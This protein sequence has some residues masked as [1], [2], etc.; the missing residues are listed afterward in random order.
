[1]GRSLSLP[2]SSPSYVAGPRRNMFDCRRRVVPSS[3]FWG[4]RARRPA[5]RN[6]RPAGP[7]HLQD[8]S[9]AARWRGHLPGRLLA[10]AD[11]R[12]G[13]SH[14]V[15]QWITACRATATGTTSAASTASGRTKASLVAQHGGLHDLFVP[16]LFPRQ[17]KP[18]W[19]R[20]RSGSARPTHKQI[21]E[22]CRCA[23]R[24]TGTP[25]RPQVRPLPLAHSL[26]AGAGRRWRSEVSAAHRAP[27]APHLP[28]RWA[29]RGPPGGRALVRRPRASALCRTPL[30]AHA[31]AARRL[32]QSRGLERIGAPASPPCAAARRSAQRSGVPLM[33][34]TPKQI[35]PDREEEQRQRRAHPRHLQL[36]APAN[37][38][39][40]F[41]DHDQHKRQR[42]KCCQHALRRR[43][44]LRGAPPRDGRRQQAKAP[45][46]T[47]PA[48]R[49]ASD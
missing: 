32:D 19:R 13:Q 34:K 15:R 27:G 8:L 5:S 49:T 10:G 20:A 39:T 4:S 18:S 6:D 22:R 25:R 24:S 44:R 46:S 17:A 40:A 23:Q 2:R 42:Q 29:R 33:L 30:G 38:L 37:C 1:M 26:D 31:P 43:A 28:R 9:G 48:T 12:R 45:S 36:E 14:H 21:L 41:A 16:I 35:E 47:T 3:V 7:H 11:P